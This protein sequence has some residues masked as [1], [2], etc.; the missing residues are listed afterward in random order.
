MID[1]KK[2]VAN[3]RKYGAILNIKVEEGNV[4]FYLFKM[5]K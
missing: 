2:P 1:R 4:K 3:W 5:G